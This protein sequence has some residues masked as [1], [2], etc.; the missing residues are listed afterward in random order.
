MVTYHI[1]RLDPPGQDGDPEY[2]VLLPSRVRRAAAGGGLKIGQMIGQSDR[3]GAKLVTKAYKSEQLLATIH[4]LF[5]AAVRINPALVPAEVA[6]LV[7][8]GQSIS[9]LI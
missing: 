8:S 7:N 5:D 9:K 1:H 6:N 3:T 2:K 4:K